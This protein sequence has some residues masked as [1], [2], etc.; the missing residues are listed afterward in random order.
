MKDM[1]VSLSNDIE[2]EAK[3][4]YKWHKHIKFILDGAG[5]SYCMCGYLLK[6]YQIISGVNLNRDALI[7]LF[8]IGEMICIQI[9]NVVFINYSK[10]GQKLKIS[11]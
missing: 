4:D 6:I 5:F 7:F 8:R 11:C 9:V 10:K 3:L 1:N 2:D